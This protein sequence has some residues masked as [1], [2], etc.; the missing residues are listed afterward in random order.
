M[1]KTW[2]QS[3][4]PVSCFLSVGFGTLIRPLI[5]ATEGRI[6]ADE[7][8]R[9]INA[10]ESALWY[11]VGDDQAVQSMA[12]LRVMTFSGGLKVLNLSLAAGHLGDFSG[13]MDMVEAL[14]R[15]KGCDR[16][17]VNGRKGWR[18]VLGPRFREYSRSY[19]M[20]VR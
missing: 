11:T 9:E 15:A 4:L 7:V 1:A 2:I 17:Q 13:N 16:I 3:G 12:V 6:S 14:A 5:D 8:W 18:K 19:E 10:A 20:E